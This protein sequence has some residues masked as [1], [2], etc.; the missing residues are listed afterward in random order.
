MLQWYL[1]IPRKLKSFHTQWNL[2]S[3][4]L[5]KYLQTLYH[6]KTPTAVGNMKQLSIHILCSIF[7]FMNIVS[8]NNQYWFLW[9]GY[10]KSAMHFAIS[11]RMRALQYF[12]STRVY[13][14][15]TD[16]KLHDTTEFIPLVNCRIMIKHL[17]LLF[18]SSIDFTIL[19][20]SRNFHNFHSLYLYNYLWSYKSCFHHQTVDE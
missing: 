20:Q 1:P 9:A 11:N 2:T 8:H 18:L 19:K 6:M 4:Y 13:N 15:E 12:D 14:N 10:I 7:R 17:T 5:W 3:I 16:W